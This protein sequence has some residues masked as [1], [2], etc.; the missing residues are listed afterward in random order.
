[1]RMQKIDYEMPKAPD[2][3]CWNCQKRYCNSAE[4]S[5]CM[6]I[7]VIGD[8]KLI[9]KNYERDAIAVKGRVENVLEYRQHE[10]GKDKPYTLRRVIRLIRTESGELIP[11]DHS[12]NE[13]DNKATAQKQREA[14]RSA[15][16]RL[17]DNGKENYSG[18]RVKGDTG[19]FSIVCDCHGKDFKVESDT[20]EGSVML[21]TKCGL[22]TK[23]CRE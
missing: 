18:E 4:Q 6:R 21:C 12:M 20:N 10:Q 16:E 8:G 9:L 7:P 17:K 2:P 15:H 3:A 1:M 14:V 19:L 22:R 23:L 11:A 5:D 13:Q